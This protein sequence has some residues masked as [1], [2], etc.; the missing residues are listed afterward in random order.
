MCA[1]EDTN[2]HHT[3]PSLQIGENLFVKSYWMYAENKFWNKVEIKTQK[4]TDLM[5]KMV[6][7]RDKKS[8][9]N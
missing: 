1:R 7:K 8:T 6:E 9:Q 4:K 5:Q 3:L 2:F